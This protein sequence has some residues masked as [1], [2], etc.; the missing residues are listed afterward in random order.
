LVILV[1]Y[2]VEVEVAS[3]ESF[4]VSS[5]GQMSLPAAVRRRWH[6]DHGGRVD[7]LDLGFG[8]LTMPEG[9]AA[10]MLDEIL[11]AES[12]YEA[13]AAEEDPDLVSR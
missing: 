6:L 7:V 9:H 12:H 5:S 13:V 10:R 2:Q 11:P 1:V 4:K 3:I 8:V